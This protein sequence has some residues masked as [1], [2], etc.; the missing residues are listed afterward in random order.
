MNAT[1]NTT[2][3]NARTAGAQVPRRIG[4]SAVAVIA[5]FATTFALS[6][7][8]DAGLHRAGV[9]PPYG[10]RMSDA[11]FVLAVVYRALVTV[12]GGWVTAR[13]A[14][15][16][17][18]RHA[19]ILAVVGTLAG[20]GGVAVSLSHPELGPLW[21]PVVLIVVAWPCIWAGARWRVRQSASA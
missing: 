5:G 13:L 19:L 11:L 12:A 2:T 21:Y 18:M 14:P 6:M 8:I 10:V 3:E 4:A 17:P 1:M 7:A 15:S 9:Y 20:L 16:G